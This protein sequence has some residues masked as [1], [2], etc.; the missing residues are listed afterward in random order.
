MTTVDE[1]FRIGLDGDEDQEFLITTNDI[2]TV[3][4]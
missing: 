2:E 1:D 4:Y 3:C